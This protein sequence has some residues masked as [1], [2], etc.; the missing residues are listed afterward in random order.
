M[1]ERF[2]KFVDGK[3]KV[4]TVE[5]SGY[6]NFDFHTLWAHL[7]ENK[8]LDAY[9]KHT[10]VVIKD[11]KSS[12]NTDNLKQTCDQ[13]KV[14]ADAEGMDVV[15]EDGVVLSKLTALEN[16]LK[17]FRAKYI[18]FGEAS[19]RTN[20]FDG[21][22][23]TQDTDIMELL[24]DGDTKA[25]ANRIIYGNSKIDYAT[26]DAKFMFGHYN[27]IETVIDTPEKFLQ[28][29]M[30]CYQKYQQAVDIVVKPKTGYV[31]ILTEILKNYKNTAKSDAENIKKIKE[32]INKILSDIAHDENKNI[33]FSEMCKR[34]TN[35]TVSIQ[36]MKFMFVNFRQNIITNLL[37][38]FICL[39][40]A[41]VAVITSVQDLDIKKESLSDNEAVNENINKL[42]L[43]AAQEAS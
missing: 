2:Q 8:T 23:Y 35:I 28:M 24:A 27:G 11:A 21:S 17:A 22:I 25:A 40:R 32:D 18:L 13:L 9:I 1:K 14:L 33:K 12:I 3:I 6:G 38:G 7:V 16:N 5:N 36:R 15:R 41:L 31:D 43:E 19:E 29:I 20:E 37:N 39:D 26:V 30:G 34:F 4:K 42:E 10:S